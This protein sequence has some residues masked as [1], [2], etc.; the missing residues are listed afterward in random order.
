MGVFAP[1]H[2]G[3]LTQIVPFEMVD[4]ALESAR[5]V[6]SRVRDLP[7]RVVVYLL[8]AGALFAD[9]GYTQVWARMIAGLD[10]PAPARPG[11]SALTQARRR[12]GSAPLRELFGLLAGP[13]AGAT[14]WRGLLVCA[15]DATTMFVPD[16]TANLSTYHRQGSGNGESGYPMLRL[17]T[18][19]ACGT[20]TVIDAVFGT[21]GISEQ[22]YAPQL[23]GCLREGMLLLADRNSAVAA[24][25]TQ[26]AETKADLLVRAKTGH[27][28]PMIE[29]SADGSWLTLKGQIVVRVIDADIEVA[30][31]GGPRRTEHYRLLTTLTDHRRYPA[32][33]L[34][35]L[36]HQRWQIETSYAEI[37]SSILNGRVLRA[38]TPNGIDQEVYALLVTHQALRIAI[39]DATHGHPGPLHASFTIALNTAR[40]QLI[41]AAA[42]IADTAIDLVGRIGRAVL[43]DP[44]PTRRPRQS[45][46]VVKRAISKH[47]AKGIIDRTNYPN[48]DITINLRKPPT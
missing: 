6:Q 18:V 24:L 31:H 10:G 43:A 16:T 5:A 48:I 12:V 15:I 23:F 27:A 45:P 25:I 14:R 22:A 37:K 7:S 9:I 38:R 41:H 34:M 35:R 33:E 8:L 11:S 29:R 28:V 26:I 42:V 4:A 36:Y 20:R 1:G 30:P 32:M 19:V 21:H 40:D 46:R 13:A 3:E 17:L 44:I 2:L 39:A 47:R